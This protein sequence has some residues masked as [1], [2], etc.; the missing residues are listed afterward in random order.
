MM[1]LSSFDSMRSLGLTAGL[2]ACAMVAGCTVGPD[3][4]K[5]KAPDVHGYTADQLT[6]TS[7]A[8]NVIAGAAQHFDEGGDIPAD[9]WTLFH[10]KALNDLIERSLKNN[11]NLNAGQAALRVAQENVLAQK[12]AYYPTASGS[13]SASHQQTSAEV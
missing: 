5:P 4:Q 13:F 3:F 12:G 6:S 11:P 2:V 10:C 8:P 9:W 1:L 7:S